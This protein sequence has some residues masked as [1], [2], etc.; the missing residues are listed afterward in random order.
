MEHPKLVKDGPQVSAV[1][2]GCMGTSYNYG[3]AVVEA[4]GMLTLSFTKSRSDSRKDNI[5]LLLP[6]TR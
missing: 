6:S 5:V 4:R 2:L 3:P 1:G